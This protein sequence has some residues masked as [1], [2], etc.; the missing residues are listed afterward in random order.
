MCNCLELHRDSVS[1]HGLWDSLDCCSLL[2]GVSDL[3]DERLKY[4]GI[5]GEAVISSLCLSAGGVFE[6]LANFGS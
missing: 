2:L 6:L 4:Y 1:K 3:E 5:Y